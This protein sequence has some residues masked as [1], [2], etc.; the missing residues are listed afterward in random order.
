MLLEQSLTSKL[1]ALYVLGSYNVDIVSEVKDFPKVGET[2]RATSTTF[3]SGGKGTNQATA[4]AKVSNN[5]HFCTKVG[6]DSFA[7]RAKK[8]LQSTQ[9]AS[10]SLYQ[11]RSVSTGNAFIMLSEQ[12]RDNMITLDLGANLTLTEQEVASEASKLESSNVLLVQL[13]NNLSAIS[14]TLQQ[15]KQHQVLTI[16]NPAP[17]SHH[18]SQ[19]IQ[20]IDVITPNE[21]EAQSL[22]NIEVIDIESAEQ[23]AKCIY[24]MG[25]KLVVITLGSK[26]CLVYDGSEFKRYLSYSSNVV[27]TC[28]A[29]DSFNGALAAS[30][31]NGVSVKDSINYANAFA[32]LA[33]ER[34]GAS[35]MPEDKDVHERMTQQFSL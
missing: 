4:A 8:H 10:L 19:L 5:V 13:E 6:S 14:Q 7:S 22:T 3:Y 35:S 17:Y 31:S 32:S 33:V 28:G 24:S 25:P 30:L 26:G 1:G 21:T 27:D 29:G 12:T 11:H 15:A 2:I 23:A 20:W 18:V 34:K 16:L 9:L